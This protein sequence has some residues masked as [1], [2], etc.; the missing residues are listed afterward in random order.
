[1]G[2]ITSGSRDCCNGR[3]RGGRSHIFGGDFAWSGSDSVI[4]FGNDHSHSEPA[5]SHPTAPYFESD[6]F[7]DSR[8]LTDAYAYA[9][10][11][12]SDL[13][14]ALGRKQASGGSSIAYS[15]VMF[16]NRQKSAR[17]DE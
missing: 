17:T 12:G 10:A 7:R 11:Y 5:A 8:T 6:Q 15:S 9:Y 4:N 14:T 1:M 3:E 16:H 13:C 2:R